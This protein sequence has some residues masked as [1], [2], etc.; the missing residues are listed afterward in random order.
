[1]KHILP[2]VLF[3]AKEPQGETR[4]YTHTCTLP[5]LELKA[6]VEVDRQLL[7]EGEQHGLREG[8]GVLVEHLIQVHL[9]AEE[10]HQVEVRGREGQL[11]GCVGIVRGEQLVD[12]L[13]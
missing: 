13:L 8:T 6:V 5:N 7:D 3:L 10:H 9:L 2:R 11:K 12:F 1:M 4:H